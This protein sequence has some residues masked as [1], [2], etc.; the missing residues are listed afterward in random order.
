[1]GLYGRFVVPR[2]IALAM[3]H[4]ML[5]PY[6]QRVAEGAT[7]RVLELGIGS[8]LNLPFYG[9]DVS[10]VI[11]VEPSPALLAMAAARGGAAR[12]PVDLLQATAEG[13]P[14]DAHSIDTVVT[15][16]T[17]CSVGDPIQVLGEARRV[18]RPGGRLL[19]CEHGRAPDARIERWQ[20]RLT[21]IWKRLAGGCHLNRKIDALVMAA[22][23][24]LDAIETGYLPRGPKF[25]G[26]IYTGRASA[27]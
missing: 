16:W 19:F 14:L 1:M 15:T 17:L 27:A 11:G 2:L 20:D 12:F 22:G 4:P 8:G 10:E 25:A 23:F 6:R 3:R 18:L 21:P 24:R 7:G 13:L 5:L 26:Y 9:A